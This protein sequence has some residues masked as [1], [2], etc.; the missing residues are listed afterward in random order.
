MS[1]IKGLFHINILEGFMTKQKYTHKG[2]RMLTGSSTL[3]VRAACICS[4][5]FRKGTAQNMRALGKE[6]DLQQTLKKL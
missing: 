1:K 5:S 3:T 6:G 2:N 4:G